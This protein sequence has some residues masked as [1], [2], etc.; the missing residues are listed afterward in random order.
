MEKCSTVNVMLFRE[1][2]VMEIW[3]V[4]LI[5]VQLIV[6]FCKFSLYY[7]ADCHTPL[8]SLSPSFS[9]SDSPIKLPLFAPSATPT[10]SYDYPSSEPSSDPTRVSLSL[11]SSCPSSHPSSSSPTME[12]SSPPHLVNTR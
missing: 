6:T 11:L 10:I 7:V 5:F 3:N 12:K 8:S 9:S 4:G 2:L 1:L